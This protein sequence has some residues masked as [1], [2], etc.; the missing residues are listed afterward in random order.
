MAEKAKR[1]VGQ[2]N[3]VIELADV[4]RHGVSV[5]PPGMQPRHC[6][7]QRGLIHVG[8]YDTCSTASELGGGGEP[9]AIRTAGDNGALPLN[10][11]IARER[12]RW[13]KPAPRGG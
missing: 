9:D 5:K 2:C 11:S 10:P 13:W 3:H 8:K 12:T 6:L 4:A 1:F 7:L